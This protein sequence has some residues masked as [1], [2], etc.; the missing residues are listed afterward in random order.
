[1]G[2]SSTNQTFSESRKKVT[3]TGFDFNFSFSRE[4]GLNVSDIYNWQTGNF[5]EENDTD[6]EVQTEALY[7][8]ARGYLRLLGQLF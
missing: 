7:G 4:S 3:Q 2:S 6:N 8:I 5:T 1:M